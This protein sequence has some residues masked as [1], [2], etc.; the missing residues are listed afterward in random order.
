MSFPDSFPGS[1]YSRII[2]CSS[3]DT[4]IANKNFHGKFFAEYISYTAEGSWP[5]FMMNPR[6]IP[7]LPPFL[8]FIPLFSPALSP[9]MYCYLGWP[10]DRATS[11]VLIYL[12]S[13]LK[14]YS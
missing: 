12:I 1:F 13:S 14:F 10:R 3:D 7:W 11:N 6:P 4:Y 9:F 2:L 8:D 5:Y